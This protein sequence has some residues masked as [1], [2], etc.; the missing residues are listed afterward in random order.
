[1]S[2]SFVWRAL[3][4]PRDPLPDGTIDLY[5]ARSLGQLVGSYPEGEDPAGSLDGEVL[6]GPLVKAWLA[7]FMAGH[8]SDNGEAEDVR[9]MLSALEQH[10]RVEIEIRR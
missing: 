5:V 8:G 1:M 2:R 10:G 6:E 7:G 4:E 3:P 9:Q